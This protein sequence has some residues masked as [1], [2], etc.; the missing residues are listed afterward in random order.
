M[1]AQHS[2][3]ETRL[4]DMEAAGIDVQVIS[5]APL[6]YCYWADP[7]LAAPAARLVNDFIAGM[8]ES[9]RG[10]FV[11]LGQIPMQS[12]EHAV[13]EMRRAVGE[14][15]FRGVEINT[16]VAGRELSERAFRPVFAAAEE[17]GCLIFLHPNG[18]TQ[19]QRLS[20]HYLINLIGNPLET[21]IALHHLIFDGVLK[22]YP[23]LKVLAAH[24]GGFAASYAGRMDHGH[25]HRPDCRLCID[26]PPS[27]YLKRIYFD[28]VVYT[29]E[30]LETLVR[31]YGADHIVLGTDYPY[32]MA[33]PDPVGFVEGANLDERQKAAILGG[34]A[35]SLLNL[36]AE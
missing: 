25:A 2:D 13:G 28:T 29:R 11:G 22:D 8:V 26:E 18:F 9:A 19:G 5:P 21:T 30:E 20:N 36:S 35:L 34:N 32:D 16:N 10:R 15:G 33:L 17:L 7:D 27:A 6:H 14:L 1:R 12:P 24:G 23:R 3:V 4:A 31:R